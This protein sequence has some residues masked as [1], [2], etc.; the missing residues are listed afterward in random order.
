MKNITRVLALLLALILVLG[1]VVTGFADGAGTSYTITVNNAVGGQIYKLYKILDLSVSE[2]K[3]AF[4]YTV[5]TDWNDFF[6]AAEGG[7]AAGAGRTYVNI[8]NL[9]YVTWKTEKDTAENH[10]AFARAAEEFAKKS[11]LTEVHKE[12]LSTDTTNRAIIFT[13]TEPGYYL[14]TS[15]LGTKAIVATTPTN[16]DVA[17][18]EKN[19]APSNDKTVK[20]NST[21]TY[22]KDNDANIGDTIEFRSIITAQAGAENYVFED[23]MS[24][25]LTSKQDATVYTNDAMTN[26]LAT[27]NYD[28]VY[29]ATGA[30][31]FKISFKPDY[32]DSINTETKLYVKYSAVLNEK[33][34]IGTTGNTNESVLKYGDTTNTKSTPKSVTTTKTWEVKVFKFHTDAT[35]NNKGLPGAIFTLSKNEQGTTPI[36]LVE[37]ENTTD[38][39]YRVAKTGETGATTEI[40]TTDTGKFTIQGLDSGTYYLT[41]TKAPGGYNKLKA[42]VKITIAN[43]G[44]V[45]VDDKDV[46]NNEVLVENKTGAEMPSTGGIG[47]TVFY[48][49][50]GILAVGAAVLLVT[51][52]RMERG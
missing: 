37:V 52:K 28:I 32:L 51:K 13:V 42:A 34:T 24:A 5:N 19:Q 11:Q 44:T 23:T 43:D 46:T 7:N 41:E 14:V 3:D 17:I 47:T 18:A 15:T 26:A 33:A 49:V 27:A 30:P 9:G 31:T 35:N 29:S 8:D 40:T 4:S 22:G 45:K 39:T 36:N 25:G 48:V 20:E 21:D 10:A 16:K 1:L 50:G 2:E 12:D 6:K 38:I